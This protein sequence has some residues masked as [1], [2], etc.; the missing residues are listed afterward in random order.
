MST[1]TQWQD[2]DDSGGLSL[3]ELLRPLRRAWLTL[4]LL[5][6]AAGVVAVGLSFL[7]PPTFTARASFLS[8]Q[9]SG[10]AAAALA[11]LGNLAALAGANAATRSP[12]EQYASLMDSVTVADRLVE[13]FDLL[14]V[15]GEETRVDARRKLQGNTRV[16]VGKK[17]GLIVVEFDDHDPKRAA[18]V[19]NQYIV[20]LRLLTGK[21]ALSEAQ[22][23]RVFF[24][25]L[26]T[27]ARDDLSKAQLELQASG[28]NR[29]AL[30]AEPR[31]A[32]EA[33][34]RTRAEVS[35]TEVRLRA[36]RQGL[37][38]SAPEVQRLEAQ[39]GA[40]QSQLAGMERADK[41]T[42]SDYLDRYREFKYQEAMFEVFARQFEAARVDEAREGALIQVLDAAT[43]PER[44]SKPKRS[45]I[46]LV[47]TALVFLLVA[48]V[49]IVRDQ[50]RTALLPASG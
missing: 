1:A 17:D 2:D 41:G 7:V 15:Y 32:A 6:L 13:R 5:P 28:F 16:T 49:L 8:P 50:R 23:R 45:V 12:A 33:Y 10:G 11:S 43:P 19:A 31:A 25:G 20:E 40:L 27:K 48:L 30:R 46:G 22:Q 18:E 29:G 21:L 38:D 26:M 47:T 36:T 35:A 42:P 3:T 44:K 9:A 34:A 14:K 39:L 37:T 24:E 4:L